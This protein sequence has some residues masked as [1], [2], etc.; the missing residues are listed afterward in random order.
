MCSPSSTLRGRVRPRTGRADEAHCQAHDDEHPSLYVK[1]GDGGRV[2]ITCRAGC[3]HA[4][5]LKAHGL[6]SSDLKSTNGTKPLA[7]LK[8]SP[9]GPADP[10][11]SDARMA[12]T[13]EH[14]LKH[15]R[16]PAQP[17]NGRHRLCADCASAGMVRASRS[18]F[19]ARTMSL[20]TSF[21]TRSGSL[22]VTS[23]AGY[24]RCSRSKGR[25]RDLFPAPETVSTE[26][27]SYLVEG[28]PDAIA[29]AVRRPSCC[30]RSGHQ[31]L[32][33]RV[34]RSVHWPRR[35]DRL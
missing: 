3:T 7:R 1:Q 25:P 13:G 30:S 15:N 28:E 4:A 5:V 34:V 10:L 6:K 26:M 11:P 16:S 27:P 22:S 32:E 31:R 23:V 17:S 33:A 21:G 9:A 14:N 35:V 20:S 18:Q 8:T 2:L 19:A 12:W 29:G 24:Q